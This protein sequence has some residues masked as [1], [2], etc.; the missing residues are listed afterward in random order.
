MQTFIRTSLCHCHSLSLASVESGLVLPFWYELTWVVP[1]EGLLNRC[2]SVCCT[3]KENDIGR[4]LLSLIK[5]RFLA[6]N[7]AT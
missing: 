3:I 4:I 5:F 6:G 7:S 1:D 2:V